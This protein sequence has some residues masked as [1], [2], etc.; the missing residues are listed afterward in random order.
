MCPPPLPRP[1]LAESGIGLIYG[2]GSLG[3]M[4]EVAKATLEAGGRVTGVIPT[5][6]CSASAC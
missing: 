4:G 3:L 6:W 2:G 5:F 1:G